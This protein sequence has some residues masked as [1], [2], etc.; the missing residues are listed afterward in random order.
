MPG[1]KRADATIP[2]RLIISVEGHEKTGKTHF[3]LTAP[4]PIGY[5]NMD[6]GAEG[7]LQR[8]ATEKEIWSTSYYDFDDHEARWDRFLEDWSE[9]LTNDF[10][11]LVVDTESTMWEYIRLARLGKLTQVMPTQYVKVNEEYNH[12]LEAAFQS[13]KNVIFIRRVKKLYIDNNWNGDYEA[14]GMNDIPYKVQVR[15]ETYRMDD[16]TFGTRILHCGPNAA[17]RYEELLDEMSDFAFLGTYVYP[18]TD[19]DDWS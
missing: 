8:F 7:V 4:E 1:F 13:D 14:V 2:N 12:M 5:F 19:L 16:G 9:A 10:R 3:A 6:L 18:D 11:S 17:V 15:L